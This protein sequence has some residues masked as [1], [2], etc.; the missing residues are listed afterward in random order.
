MQRS[1]HLTKTSERILELLTNCDIPLTVY[2]ISDKTKIPIPSIYRN[3]GIL[4]RDNLLK[5]FELH[6]VNY[7]YPAGRHTHY[8]V[9]NNCNSIIP[10]KFCEVEESKV[11]KSTGAKVI[12]HMVIFY[13]ICRNCLERRR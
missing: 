12:E 6:G 1:T 5:S 4:E 3:V 13:G 7:Y 10:V 11:E 8:F 2:Q 9:C